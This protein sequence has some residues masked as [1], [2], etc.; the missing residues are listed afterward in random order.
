[1]STVELKS[2]VL[3]E[4]LSVAA[5]AVYLSTLG[6]SVFLLFLCQYRSFVLKTQLQPQPDAFAPV[7]PLGNAAM[8]PSHCV[9]ISL[10]LPV[11][12]Y[13]RWTS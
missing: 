12:E 4:P 3:S 9:L 5:V 6:A 2:L 11:K 1:M 7:K 10:E 8:F 13:Q